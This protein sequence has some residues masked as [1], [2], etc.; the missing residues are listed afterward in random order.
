ME[1]V[2][3]EGW[4]DPDGHMNDDWFEPSIYKN[5]LDS[6]P[7]ATDKGKYSPP[8]V[9]EST[10]ENQVIEE[11]KETEKIM[12]LPSSNTNASLVLLSLIH[13]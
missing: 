9:E 12:D 8:K 3:T 10:E 4:Y 6:M 5:P 11:P 7:I 2:V 13:I 1:V